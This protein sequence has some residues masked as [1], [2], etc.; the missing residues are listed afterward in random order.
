M[1]FLAAVAASATGLMEFGGTSGH[2]FVGHGV[3]HVL[4]RL[5]TD[6][7]GTGLTGNATTHFY[8]EAALDHFGTHSTVG[9][10]SEKFWRQRFYTDQTFWCGEGCP[11]FV[12]IGGEG[13]QGERRVSGCCV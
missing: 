10:A 3:N 11:I 1:V 13:P 8:K 7:V 6:L 5:D 12:Y 4:Q 9:S 2:Q